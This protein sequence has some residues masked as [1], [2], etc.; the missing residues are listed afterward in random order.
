MFR[1]VRVQ[2][3]RLRFR[4]TDALGR[5]PRLPP[6]SVGRHCLVG[7]GG[8]DFYFDKLRRY[9]PVFKMLWGSGRLKVGVAGFARAARLFADHAGAL[10]PVNIDIKPLVPK[11]FLRCMEGDDHAHYR[12][13]FADAFS[14]DLIDGRES[15]IRD[16]IARELTTLVSVRA[17]GLSRSEQLELTLN[18]VAT[19]ALVACFFGVRPSDPAFPGLER[20]F[21]RLGPRGIVHPLGD[22]QL[23]AFEELS[24]A[25]RALVRDG[26]SEASDSAD[27]VLERLSRASGGAPV[28]ETVVGNVIFMAEMGRHDV[29][30]LMRWLLKYL[31]DD[32]GA[33]HE[34]RGLSAA[35]GKEGP[36]GLF[37]EACVLETLRLDQAEGLNRRATREFNFDGYRIPVNTDVTVLLRE[38]HGDPD[39]FAQP[40]RFDPHRFLGQRYT[41]D[42]YAPFGLG[43]H[44]CLADA[45]VVRLGALFVEELVDGFDW[46]VMSDGPVHQGRFHWQPSLDFAIELTARSRPSAEPD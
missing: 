38:T 32:E 31:S 11:G 3:A 6:G 39:V 17:S 35:G 44:R 22:E 27:T 15:E 42:E 33:R 36:R 29:C 19:R 37:A 20:G 24:E 10:V 14:V 16:G 2:L 21:A 7:L 41:S 45:F 9:G 30:G 18:R 8:R 13:V 12:R 4:V 26:G 25:I 34:L 1:K 46:S 28:D 23:A 5:A 40:S 43:K